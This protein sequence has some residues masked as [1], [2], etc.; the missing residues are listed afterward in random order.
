MVAILFYTGFPA[1]AD[2]EKLTKAI[3]EGALAIF[4]A[5]RTLGTEP[6]AEQLVTR[7]ATKGGITE[8]GL[9]HLLPESEL[10]F[11]KTFQTSLERGK[12]LNKL[13]SGK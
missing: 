13:N 9:Q 3:F 5:E 8:A 2:A 1:H 6:S 4:S 12:E 11:K 10:S 7:V